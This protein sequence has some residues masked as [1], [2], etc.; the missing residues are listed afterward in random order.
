MFGRRTQRAALALALLVALPPLARGQGAEASFSP[1]DDCEAQALA[2]LDRARQTVDVAQ[3]NVRNDVFLVKLAELRARGVRVRLVV[4]AKNAANPWNV[5]DD[6]FEAQ[7]FDIVRHENTR[8]PYAIMHH[9]FTVVDGTWVMTGSYNWNET[10]QRVNDENLV[11]LRDPALAAAYT[12]EF[13]AL[14]GGPEVRGP[15]TSGSYTVR[16]SPRDDARGGLIAALRGAQRRIRVA[17]FS[18]TDGPL[19]RELAAA[20]RRGVA[21]ELVVEEKQARNTRA[22]E[23]VAA[24]GATVHVVANRSSPHSA[25]HQKF[26][27]IDDRLVVT[28]AC[29]W[30][31]T[32]LTHSNEDVLFADDPALARAY[33]RAFGEL[34]ARYVPQAFDPDAYGFEGEGRDTIRLNLVVRCDRTRWG[35]AVVLVGEHPALGGWDPARGV[36]LT[37][38]ADLFPIWTGK[39]TLPRGASTAWK[40]VLR[41]ADGNVRWEE[42]WDRTFDGSPRGVAALLDADFRAPPEPAPTPDAAGAGHAG[43]GAADATTPAPDP[44]AT[45]GSGQPGQ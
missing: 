10:A 36:V 11:V 2:V 37:T 31:F 6:V 4:D 3:Y 45:P 34:V 28:G 25:M 44:V 38:H 5:L 9:K 35:E 23:T 19:A 15:T 30:T 32:A 12:R 42:G 40:L 21:V 41:D 7:G 17:M 8:H 43:S 33:T 24:G 27:V 20:A 18:F 22:D 16:F 26:A 1:W 39:A 14:R 13:E 29:N